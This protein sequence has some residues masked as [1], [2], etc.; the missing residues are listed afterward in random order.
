MP[1]QLVVVV[2]APLPP[3]RRQGFLLLRLFLLPQQP[4]LF[5]A[6]PLQLLPSLLFCSCWTIYS[7]QHA[8]RKVHRDCEI[9]EPWSQRLAEEFRLR[10]LATEGAWG[11]VRVA[12][13]KHVPSQDRGVRESV[14]D[15]V[16]NMA[17]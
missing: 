16:H 15:I 7:T 17:L 4:Q 14:V 13:N 9:I 11:A 1:L 3:H 10:Q 6:L 2:V 12:V 8:L 5:H